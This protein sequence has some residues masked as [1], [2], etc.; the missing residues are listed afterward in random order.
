M[1]ARMRE[2]QR[3]KNVSQAAHIEPA[4]EGSVSQ[5]SDDEPWYR[6]EF[7]VEHDVLYLDRLQTSLTHFRVMD[8]YLS[9]LPPRTR[10]QLVLVDEQSNEVIARRTV[11]PTILSSPQP[12]TSGN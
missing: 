5:S 12:V 11:N 10:G 1:M 3:M 2:C 9:S 6:V 7:R 4:G 8:V